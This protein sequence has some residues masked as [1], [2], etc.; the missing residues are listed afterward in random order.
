[1][2]YFS[3]YDTTDRYAEMTDAA[4]GGLMS[5]PQEWQREL[6]AI[7]LLEGNVNN[8][9]YLQFIENGGSQY[10]DYAVAALRKM[11]AN[12]MAQIIEACHLLVLK[13]TDAGL[14]DSE[15]FRNLIPN[16]IVR[17]D[18]SIFT[19]PPS[20]I[21]DQVMSRIYDLSYEFMEYPDDIATLGAAYYAP[22]VKEGT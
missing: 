2:T 8:G 13:H 7:S 22:F 15:R 9:G 1:M 14:Q 19:P 18:G 11:G 17:D 10:Y 20:P 16:E 4:N 6:A 5:L 3:W 21:P 12:K